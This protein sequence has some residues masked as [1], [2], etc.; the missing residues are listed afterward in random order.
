MEWVGSL[1][2]RV[3]VGARRTVE[4]AGHTLTLLLA[5]LGHGE[6]NKNQA[7]HPPQD[8]DRYG[9]DRHAEQEHTQDQYKNI[10][11]KHDQ[12]PFLLTSCSLSQ[13]WHQVN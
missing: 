7:R 9:N 3:R 5:A 1:E 4:S 2:Q 11:F 12:L 6:G 8:G 10:F 13:N